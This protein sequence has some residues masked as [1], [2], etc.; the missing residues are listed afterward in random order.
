M[1][2]ELAGSL[3]NDV[4]LFE[5]GPCKFGSMVGLIREGEFNRKFKLLFE[6]VIDDGGDV[7]GPIASLLGVRACVRLWKSDLLVDKD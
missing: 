3:G 7:G 4:A 1:L 5:E 2:G 6:V